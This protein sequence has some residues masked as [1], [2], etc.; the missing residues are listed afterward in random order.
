MKIIRFVLE[1]ILIVEVMLLVLYFAKTFFNVDI[2]I[3]NLIVDNGLKYLTPISIPALVLYFLTYI[4]DL[5]IVKI[6]IGIALG[7][8]ILYYLIRICNGEFVW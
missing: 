4:L 6:A 5:K 2:S 7:G 8:I 1:K 3:V